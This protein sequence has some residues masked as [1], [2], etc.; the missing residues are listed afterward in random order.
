MAA[1]WLWCV[2]Y[3]VTVLWNIQKSNPKAKTLEG[4]HSLDDK[5]NCRKNYVKTL[6]GT[7]VAIVVVASDKVYEVDKMHLKVS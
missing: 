2:F 1:R 7:A 3:S 6:T 4:F 5:N